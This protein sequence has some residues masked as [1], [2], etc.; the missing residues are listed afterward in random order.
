MAED[1]WLIILLLRE[2]EVVAEGRRKADAR[3]GR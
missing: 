2:K 1:G 3:L